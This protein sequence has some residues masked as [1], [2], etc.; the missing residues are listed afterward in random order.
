M[1]ERSHTE[2]RVDWDRVESA[3]QFER[4]YVEVVYRVFRVLIRT[5]TLSER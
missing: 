1:C 5:A 3:C 4:T 2:Q